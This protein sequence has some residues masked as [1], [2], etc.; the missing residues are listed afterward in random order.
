M[1]IGPDKSMMFANRLR[2]LPSL[3]LLTCLCL[4][5]ASCEAP[6]ISTTAEAKMPAAPAKETAPSEGA[7][8]VAADAAENTAKKTAPSE[9]SHALEP[10]GYVQKAELR[11]MP[12]G[13]VDGDTLKAVGFGESLRLLNLDT[14]EVFRDRGKQAKAAQNWETYLAE[15]AGDE[16]SQTFATPMGEKARDFARNFFRGV[17]K[18]WVEYQS[19]VYTH[20]FF[21]RHLALVWVKKDGEWRNYN[22]EAVRAGMSPYYT[23]YGYS[24]R[25]HEAFRRAEREAK[26]QRR[27]IWAPGAKSYPDYDARIAWWNERA[28][29][30]EAFR[31]HA[32][33][34]PGVIDLASDTAFAD[35]RRRL[36]QRVVV[37]GDPQSFAERS[38][39]QRIRLSY[40]YRRDLPVVAFEPVDMR[41]AAVDPDEEHFIYVEG[42]VTMYR[43]DPQIRYDE[44]SWMRSGK[45]PPTR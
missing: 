23:K 15:E 35:L 6:K 10:T 3:L 16:G 19:P 32:Q 14:E 11:D 34:R 1:L 5:F 4:G 28:E 25:L 29:Q 44:K 41:K 2:T 39:P 18:I 37:F 36:G 42:V 43:G 12:D 13:V 9:V 7:A 26:E 24:V 30:I 22:L 8:P 40:R 31:R 33:G 20:G 45:N 21:D 27:G 38:N 17:E